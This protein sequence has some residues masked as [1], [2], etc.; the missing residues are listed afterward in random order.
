MTNVRIS[1]NLKGEFTQAHIELRGF[2]M[3]ISFDDYIALL[4]AIKKASFVNSRCEKS[5]NDGN[6]DNILGDIFV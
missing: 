5:E 6:Y 1:K 4:N 3:S 2:S